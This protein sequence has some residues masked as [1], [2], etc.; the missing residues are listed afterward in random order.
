MKLY[1]INT[2]IQS[3]I[4]LETGELLDRE[5]FDS[6]QGEKKDKVKNIALWIKNLES[7]AEQLKQEARRFQARQKAA[8]NKAKRL[9]D[10]LAMC[11]RGESYK[12]IQ[13]TI[14]WS[15]STYVDVIDEIVLADKWKK[16]SY[17]VDKAGLMTAL[18]AGENIA[19]AKLGERQSMKIS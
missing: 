4:D 18:R 13:Y 17:S 16:V 6:L 19:G 15:N 1:E 11:I 7:D 5:L 8:E 2:H 9:R 3:C 12:D 10:Y 14:E